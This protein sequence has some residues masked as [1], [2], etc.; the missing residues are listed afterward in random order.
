MP[1]A[2]GADDKNIFLTLFWPG[3]S[4][5]CTA[6]NTVQLEQ[7]ERCVLTAE[8]TGAFDRDLDLPFFPT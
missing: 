1:V 8:F 6:R 4:G 3:L 2:G 7:R 5:L